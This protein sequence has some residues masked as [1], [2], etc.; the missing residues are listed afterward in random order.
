MDLIRLEGAG[1][2]VIVRIAGKQS[3]DRASGADGLVGEI[4]VDTAFVRGSIAAEVFPDDL[5]EWQ[6]TLDA[7]DCGED[8]GW[9]E[10]KRPTELLIGLDEDGER[11]H[12]TVTDRSAS[13]TSVTITVD[14]PDTWFDDAYHRLELVQQAWP[15]DDARG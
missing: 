6:E 2:S 1:G 5:T 15:L 12:V 3:A 8:I 9:R 7:L 4:L 11:A 13:P 14:L 10:G